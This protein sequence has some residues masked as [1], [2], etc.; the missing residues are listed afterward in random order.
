MPGW[1]NWQTQAINTLSNQVIAT[2]PGGQACQALVF[3]PPAVPKGLRQVVAG[4]QQSGN[5]RFLEIVPAGA[6]QPVQV[7]LP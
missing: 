2:F 7:Q 4:T 3:V 6:T 1:R 5:R